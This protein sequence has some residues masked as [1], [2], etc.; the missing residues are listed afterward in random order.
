M[1]VGGGLATRCFDDLRLLTGD[2]GY[3]TLE[4]RA[5]TLLETLPDGLDT[6]AAMIRSRRAAGS[7]VS[8]REQQRPR[9]SGAFICH[10][11][12]TQLITPTSDPPI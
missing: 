11:A 8:P 6:A 1:E 4:A 9:R 7:T 5:A 3:A 2:R 12:F 10:V